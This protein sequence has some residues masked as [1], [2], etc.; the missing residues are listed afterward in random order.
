MLEDYIINEDSP[1]PSQVT[2]SNG[3]PEGAQ[4]R[5]KFSCYWSGGWFYGHQ[6]AK[7]LGESRDQQELCLEVNGEHFHA[8]RADLLSRQGPAHSRL[9]RIRYPDVEVHLSTGHD[10]N[11]IA[12]LGTATGA[13]RRAGHSA[14]AEQLAK[15]LIQ[16]ESYDQALNLVQR[17][18]H[19]T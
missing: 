10:G 15:D 16:T 12:I 5:H 7:I 8:R 11:I 14:A 3:C 4:G 17:T 13:L 1:E 6:A 19:V 9:S 18:V 2:C